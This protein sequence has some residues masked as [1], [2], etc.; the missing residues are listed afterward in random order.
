MNMFPLLFSSF[1]TII[2]RSSSVLVVGIASGL[3]G[4][5]QSGEPAPASHK[6]V[7]THRGIYQPSRGLIQ[8]L[9]T[10][11]NLLIQGGF[12]A[13]VVGQPVTLLHT[14]TSPVVSTV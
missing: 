8:L 4:T 3:R 14:P 11:Q 5:G 2:V 12:I 7:S 6:R 1:P 10:S 9:S 13:S